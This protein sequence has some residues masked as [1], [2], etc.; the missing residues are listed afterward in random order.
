MNLPRGCVVKNIRFP[1]NRRPAHVKPGHP[2]KYDGGHRPPQA[3]Q[4]PQQR[5]HVLSP[6]QRTEINDPV[7]YH[8]QQHRRRLE[9]I[10]QEETKRQSHLVRSHPRHQV[11]NH[12]SP[13][14][15]GVRI[16]EVAY[17]PRTGPP[18]PYN[19]HWIAGQ[20]PRKYHYLRT[21]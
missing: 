14:D 15:N 9:E 13:G 8:Q 3:Q 4:Q 2:S 6:H 20:T 16:N 18:H 1:N 19:K 17:R 7:Q 11:N 12:I 21:T 10:L 5:A